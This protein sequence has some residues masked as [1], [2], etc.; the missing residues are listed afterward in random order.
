LTVN[1]TARASLPNYI[2]GTS[3][4]ITVAGDP[5]TY[6]LRGN[7][8]RALLQDKDTVF[9]L[10]VPSDVQQA[11]AAKLRAGKTASAEVRV[12]VQDPQGTKTVIK[13][14]VQLTL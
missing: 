7:G 11:V 3:G 10:G 8:Y 5:T 2:A 1:V 13:R 12:T 9:A 6:K 4:T 14:T